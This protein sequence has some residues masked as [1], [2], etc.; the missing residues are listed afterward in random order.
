L[1]TSA[2]VCGCEV[3]HIRI[4][5]R[6]GVRLRLGRVTD[7]RI[8]LFDAAR[9]N[10]RDSFDAQERGACGHLE[11]PRRLGLDLFAYQ[12]VQPF[13]GG[14]VDLDP[15]AFV[16]QSLGRH[17]PADDPYAAVAGGSASTE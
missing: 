14:E 17:R 16:K 3:S 12:R 10:F 2:I 15:E 9:I 11:N 13:A 8:L 5:E 4:Q 6:A 1:L 7:A